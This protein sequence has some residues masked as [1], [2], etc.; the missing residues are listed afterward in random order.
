[1]NCDNLVLHPFP[2]RRSSDLAVAHETFLA[3]SLT[4]DATTGRTPQLEDDALFRE[5]SRNVQVTDSGN[6][7]F[8]VSYKNRNPKVAQQVVAR[9]E[10]HTSELQSLAY[11]VCRL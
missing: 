10:E 11:L 9:S 7:L 8:V 6:N 1:S 2:T 4:L 3:E 5:I